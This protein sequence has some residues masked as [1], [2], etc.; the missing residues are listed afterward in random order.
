MK[1]ISVINK[2]VENYKFE[3]LE[4]INFNFVEY[5][6]CKFIGLDFKSISFENVVFNNCEFRH[7]LL[8]NCNIVNKSICAFYYCNLIN[9][10]SR[11]CNFKN[12][13]IKRTSF[14]SVEFKDCFLGQCNLIK[15]SYIN[16]KF[17]DNCNLSNC[18]IK[19]CSKEFDMQFIND[20]YTCKLNLGSYIGGFRYKHSIKVDDDFYINICNTYLAFAN[21]YLKNDLQDKYGFCFYESKKALHRTL[22]GY[23]KLKSTLSYYICGYGEKP[24]RT[25]TV[26]LFIVL[27]C[28]FIYI[29]AGIETSSGMIKYSLNMNSIL[30]LMFI[31]DFFYCFNFSLVTFATVGYGNVIPIGVISNIVSDLEITLGVLM[32]GI[33]TSTIV[34]KMTR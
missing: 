28:A 1:D 27:F 3:S 16:V 31:K 17:I 12:I 14:K 23:S 7:C 13:I 8:E 22:K 10:S 21:Q 25:F 15:N 6:N 2:V 30:N 11:K 33:W 24:F 20:S 9:I 19:G 5:R 4:E 32:V 29:F 18:I 34:R 26:S